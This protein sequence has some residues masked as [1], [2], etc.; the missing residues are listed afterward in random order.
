M[1]MVRVLDRA[2]HHGRA[3]RIENKV[4]IDIGDNH[5]LPPH[6][7]IVFIARKTISRVFSGCDDAIDAGQ[8]RGLLQELV[9]PRC[10]RL[11]LEV[12]VQLDMQNPL[13]GMQ[14]Q[15]IQQPCL[16]E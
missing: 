5:V 3:G 1:P 13:V 11:R 7:R 2:R 9:K 12:L 6:V 14:G 15:P 10:I 16:F 4:L 8:A